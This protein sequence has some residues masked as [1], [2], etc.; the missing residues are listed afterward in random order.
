MMFSAAAHEF[1][2]D[3]ILG[4]FAAGMVVRLASGGE[5]EDAL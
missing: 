2:L 3:L 1:G 5:K 4:A